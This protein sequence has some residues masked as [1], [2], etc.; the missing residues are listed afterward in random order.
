MGVCT[1]LG[2]MLRLISDG[3]KDGFFFS[4]PIFIYFFPLWFDKRRRC[5]WKAPWPLLWSRTVNWYLGCQANYNRFEHSRLRCA[6]SFSIG[7]FRW[8]FT[9]NFDHWMD[10]CSNRGYL[11]DSC[12][13]IPLN[14]SVWRFITVQV[15][16]FRIVDGIS[17]WLR[18]IRI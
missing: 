9:R 13:S 5:R 3:S 2:K 10:G 17:L 14:W 16:K 12:A 11:G 1:H 6:F 8:K 4:V 15:W 7:Q 18:T